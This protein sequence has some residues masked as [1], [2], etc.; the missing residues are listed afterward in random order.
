MKRT[1]IIILSILGIVAGTY[2]LYTVVTNYNN[3]FENAELKSE[4]AQQMLST[5]SA[6]SEDRSGVVLLY[7]KGCPVCEKQDVA[8]I[9]EL[10]K[11]EKNGVGVSYIEVS[12]GVPENFKAY[13]NDQEGVLKNF[14][15]PYAIAL[16][17]RNKTNGNMN[18]AYSIRL[19]SKKNIETFMNKFK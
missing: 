5:L 7:K 19:D 15:V 3:T 9:P 14:H 2:G 16:S 1:L 4:P 13:I 11:L 12:K 8:I 18:I 10:E 6:R 17:N